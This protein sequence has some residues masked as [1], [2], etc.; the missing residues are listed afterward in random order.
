MATREALDVVPS[1]SLNLRATT[2]SR[3]LLATDWC[4]PLRDLH[5]APVCGSDRQL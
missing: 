3:R 1:D 5:L 4:L 2:Q